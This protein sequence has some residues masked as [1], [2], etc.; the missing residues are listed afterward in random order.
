MKNSNTFK[1]N[2][3][4]KLRSLHG[5]YDMLYKSGRLVQHYQEDFLFLMQ[6]LIEL[7]ETLKLS[8]AEIVNINNIILILELDNK[9]ARDKAI[10]ENKQIFIDLIEN[11]L[12]HMLKIVSYKSILESEQLYGIELHDNWSNNFEEE[13]KQ[14]ISLNPIEKYALDLFESE[15]FPLNC[16]TA[17]A[18]LLSSTFPTANIEILNSEEE[19]LSNLREI[20]PDID[21]VLPHMIIEKGVP[22]TGGSYDMYYSHHEH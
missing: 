17:G 14:I 16:L 18:S 12:Y 10:L 15:E 11:Y 5:I 3:I 9:S 19:F 13:L 20:Y 6:V 1:Y 21:D 22:L 4:I 7:K 2:L 8:N